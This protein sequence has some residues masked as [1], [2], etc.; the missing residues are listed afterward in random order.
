MVTRHLYWILTGPSIAVWCF[1][2]G[3][4]AIPLVLK[5]LAKSRGFLFADFW[6]F[7]YL[8]QRILISPGSILKINI[9][10]NHHIASPPYETRYKVLGTNIQ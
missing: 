7:I 3:V 10:C 2:P 5:R 4:F 9:S 1:T 8:P 6:L